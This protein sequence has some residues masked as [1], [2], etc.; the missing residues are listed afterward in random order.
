MCVQTSGFKRQGVYVTTPTFLMPPTEVTKQ[1]A[2][3]AYRCL[4]DPRRGMMRR[5]LPV[6]VDLR[7]HHFLYG[8]PEV[9]PT[10]LLPAI[11][12]HTT[13]EQ[14]LRL[15]MEYVALSQELLQA[16]LC[17]RQLRR[18]VR[19]YRDRCTLLRRPAYTAP[20]RIPCSEESHSDSE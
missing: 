18:T 14:L 16:R 6:G 19:H 7:V 17:T 5:V 20:L 10:M 4:W 11:Y 12:E 8:A 1:D 15:R 9:D 3:Y 13:V 2:R